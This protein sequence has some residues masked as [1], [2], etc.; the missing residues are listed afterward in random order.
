MTMAVERKD[1]AL[2]AAFLKSPLA[3]LAAAF[4]AVA[5]LLAMPL[6][7]PI[8][9]M[10]WDV[11]VYY[12]GANRIF[13]GQVPSI[14]FFA[15][16]GALS[17][18]L[19]AGAL[20]LFPNG[21]A[22]LLAHWSLLAVTAPLMALVV[23][24]VDVKSRATA[25]ALL[26]P[27]LI[28][29]LL[30]FNGREFYPFPSS[31]GFGIYNRQ[32]CQV[33]YVLMAAL[34]F[35]RGQLLLALIVTASVTAL[36]FLKITGFVAALMLCAFAFAAGRLAF[37]YAVASA[38]AFAAILAG[39][40][41]ASGLVSS[42]I[43]DIL[44]LVATNSETLLPRLVQSVSINFGVVASSLAL[45]LVLLFADRKRL[46]AQAT[47]IL[48]RPRPAAVVTF[49]DNNA[50]WL[51][52]AIIAGVFFE[53]QNTGSQAMIF[54]WPVLWS[55]FSRI[56]A[57]MA[58][59]KLM[60]AT[61]AL[62]AAAYLPM[63]INTVE[64]ASRTYIGAINTVPLAHDN[65]KSLGNVTT[66]EPVLKRAELMLA[67]HPKHPGVLDEIALNKELPA[68]LLYSDLDFQI[69]HLM[70]IDRAI[71]SIRALEAAKGIEFETIM[72]LSF[73]NPVPW[74]M[75]RSAP[76]HIA[77]GADP[78]RAVPEPDAEV[79]AAV[80]EVDLALY[81]KCPATW[82]NMRLLQIYGEALKDHRKIE[83]DACFSAYVHPR[84]AGKLD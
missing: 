26:I 71:G 7:A 81:P 33:L 55:I 25:Y 67:V 5:I 56:P 36:F 13:D 6:S 83:L 54:I 42:Y 27:F 57:M 40:E 82:A 38:L 70:T 37:R 12:D 45:C 72:M 76:L 4:A 51:G 30:P 49:L 29:A 11:Y 52:A 48:R 44:A 9:P 10:Y 78:F 22:T 8:G 59:P 19:F 73:A 20:A 79:L 43:G 28:F 65:L 15:P 77:I 2:G 64:R 1:A 41:L 24:Q 66:R 23:W 16:V 60:M 14:D 46:G 17:Y 31:D 39:I 80:R 21:Q 53:A 58:T 61:A 63:T 84:L 75:D 68:P 18:Y 34:M 74:L 69:T 32:V 35:V 62:A 50:F 47:D 3:L